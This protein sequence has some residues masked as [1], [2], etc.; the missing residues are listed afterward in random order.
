MGRAGPST[1]VNITSPSEVNPKTKV[2][3]L[4]VGVVHGLVTSSH[5]RKIYY[6]SYT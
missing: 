5:E 3:G 4:L 1:M 6:Y 2:S